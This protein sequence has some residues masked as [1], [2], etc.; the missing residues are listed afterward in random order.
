M[1]FLSRRFH[2]SSS[3]YGS[4]LVLVASLILVRA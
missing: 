4:E 3:V 1:D 2:T